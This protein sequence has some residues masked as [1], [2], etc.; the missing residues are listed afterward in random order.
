MPSLRALRLGVGIVL[1]YLHVSPV[2]IV[3]NYNN[4]VLYTGTLHK[5]S[6]DQNW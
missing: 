5:Q 4:N 1:S 6:K 2:V 3:M